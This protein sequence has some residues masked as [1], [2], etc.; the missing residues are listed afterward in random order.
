MGPGGYSGIFGVCGAV[1]GD[2]WPFYLWV[3][4]GRAVIG[5]GCEKIRRAVGG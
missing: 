5:R 2:Y 1:R 4:S 3:E